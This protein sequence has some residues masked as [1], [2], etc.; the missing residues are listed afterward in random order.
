LL[1]PMRSNDGTPNPGRAD[2]F[3]YGVEQG[4][5]HMSGEQLIVDLIAEIRRCLE[6]IGRRSDG[7]GEVLDGF[8][9]VMH[10][11][12]KVN[13]PTPRRQPVC[14]TIDDVLG[15]ARQQGMRSLADATA[16]ADPYLRWI[17]YDEY[18]RDEIGEAMLHNHA[19]AELI[20]SEEAPLQAD[21]FAL[22]VFLIGANILYR[23]HRHPAPELYLP[24]NGPSSWRF[25]RGV[26]AQRRAGQPVWN[27]ANAVH[28][29]LVG[30]EPLLMVYAWTRDVSLPAVIV[31]AS[32]WAE[33]EGSRGQSGA[34]SP[35][36]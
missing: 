27:E 19:F 33:I 24:Y 11:P 26:W 5:L 1:Q 15:L 21:S 8:T 13:L 28:A 4:M 29:T 6:E 32:D 30:A 36:G 34:P 10:R 31:P 12:R 7:V 14:D 18:P 20:G 17:I 22:G 9:G 25:D 3:Q 23:D 2:R 35:M 16:A